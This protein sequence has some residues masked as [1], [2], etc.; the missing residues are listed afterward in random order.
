MKLVP[1]VLLL[2]ILVFISF[3]SIADFIL[4]PGHPITFDGHI[5]MTT[6]NQFAQ[7]LTDGEFPVRWSNNFA[8]F[9]HPLPLIAHQIPAYLGGI[10]IAIGLKTEVA[11]IT[12][13]FLAITSATFLY[14][15][16]FK[17][18]SNTQ[19]AVTATVLAT[20]I[21]YRAINI[22]T[23]GA[24]PE[25]LAMSFLPLLLLSV[26]W[27]Q[28]K[29]TRL[30]GLIFLYLGI[31][32]TALIHP[33]MLLIFA[34]PVAAY[35]LFSLFTKA[36][37]K[38]KKEILLQSGLSIA[39]AI[40]SVSYYLFPLLIE[41]R[42]FHQV[43]LEPNFTSE[44]FLS[45][46]QL[47]DPQWYYTFTH[48][49]P[50][51]NYIKYGVIELI[52]LLV[53]LSTSIYFIKKKK[54]TDNE[55]SFI[56]WSVIAVLSTLLLLPISKPFYYVPIV[57]MIQ[58]PWRF[59]SI[60]QFV[61]PLLFVSL[62]QHFKKL[63]R[64]PLLLLIIAIVLFLRLPQFYGKNYIHQPESDYIF[65]KANLHSTN[66]N[67]VWSSDTDDYPTKTQQAEIIEGEGVLTSLDERNSSR[68]YQV[69]ADT[70]LRI[71]ENTFYFPGWKVFV[72]GE[73]TTIQYQD[74]S[75]RGLITFTV[76][77]G[78]HEVIVKYT[79][80]MTRKVTDL[81]TLFGL[82][83]SALY[84]YILKFRPSILKVLK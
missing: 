34:F 19:L 71:L 7:A 10:L 81:L 59:L 48:P 67:T 64:T 32:L 66:L 6:M 58:Y 11:F 35:F 38:Q 25:I 16:F 73:A 47:I 17:K 15:I 8:N 36:N 83:T 43:K 45:L 31:L 2:L 56:F 30:K 54:W 76:P 44:M 20:F 13:L 4:R 49:G 21:P 75:Y 70:Q 79:Q 52:I 55:K 24:L 29:K 51:A 27:I 12:V 46:K 9:G 62:F 33:M 53:S 26:E 28:I 39:L 23:R 82:L 65:N 84:F 42:Y 68:K 22:Y 74:P 50:R 77:S 41:L 80:T 14:F 61:I 1:N 57:E 18:I 78:E 3:L 5:H 72:D 40:A 69:S 60:L 37:K 63:Q